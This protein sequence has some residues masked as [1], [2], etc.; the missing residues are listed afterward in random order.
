MDRFGC[1]HQRRLQGRG[2]QGFEIAASDLGIGVLGADDLA[3][4][5]QSDLPA[6]RSGRLRQDGLV[7]RS[8]ATAYRAATAMEHAQPDR[9]AAAG[10]EFVE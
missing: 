1:R 5:G 8:A 4:L 3:L 7:A 6:Y 10:S 2:D 9:R